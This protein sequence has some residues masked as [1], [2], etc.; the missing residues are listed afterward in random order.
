MAGYRSCEERNQA[1]MERRAALMVA[2]SQDW[3]Q[4]GSRPELLQS[5]GPRHRREIAWRNTAFRQAAPGFAKI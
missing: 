3:R 5:L 2:S 1:S 4:R